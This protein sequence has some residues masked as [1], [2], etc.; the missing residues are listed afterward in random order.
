MRN[1]RRSVRT[2]LW[3]AAAITVLAGCS[4]PA[5]VPAGQVSPAMTAPS[6]TAPPAASTPAPTAP[7]PTAPA[8]ATP[9]AP[10]RSEADS[11]PAAGGQRPDEQVVKNP[12]DIMVLV[13]KRFMLPAEYR[14]ADLVEPKV[15]FIFKE[16]DEKRLMRKEAAHALELMFAAAKKD[17][18][19]LAGVSGFR[20]YDTQKSLFAYYVRTQGEE[21]ARKYSAEPGHSEHQTGLAMDVSGSTGQCAADDCFAGTPEAKWLAEHAPEFGFIIRYPKGKESVT[22]YNYE[23]WHVR[24]VGTAVSKQIAAKGLTLEEYLDQA[25]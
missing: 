12:D 14:P 7:A 6:P 20:S 18:I 4:R 15:P 19:D 24:Y 22:G 8:P 25:R 16:W 3:V 9:A 5:S 17:G 2:A 23:P 13:N 1:V 11:K 21:V 10:P